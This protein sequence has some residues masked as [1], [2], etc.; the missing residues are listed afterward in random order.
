MVALIIPT[1]APIIPGPPQGRWTYADWES[2]PDDGNRYEII[3]GVLY[4][5]TARASFTSGLSAGWITS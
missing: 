5:T 4:M 1:D 2:L 3:D